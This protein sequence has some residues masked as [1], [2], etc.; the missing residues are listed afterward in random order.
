[1]DDQALISRSVPA[2]WQ[3]EPYGTP[4]VYVLSPGSHQGFV[5]VD[6]KRRLFALGMCQPRGTPDAA[7]VGRN[8]KAALVHA[9]V[10]AHQAAMA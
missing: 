4:G 10:A 2:G 6:M 7:F 8:W 3:V 9:A 5:S 1:M